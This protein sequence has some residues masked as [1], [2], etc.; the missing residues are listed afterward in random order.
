M[1][2]ASL[3]FCLIWIS[4]LRRIFVFLWL[5]GWQGQR[6]AKF[7]KHCMCDKL[8]QCLGMVSS[9]QILYDFPTKSILCGWCS[10]VCNEWKPLGAFHLSGKKLESTWNAGG[11]SPP[12][13]IAT[14]TDWSINEHVFYLAV[15]LWMP[16]AAVSVK[17]LLLQEKILLES[18]SEPS[19][20]NVKHQ[21]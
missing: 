6:P 12:F 4:R 13:H 5:C 16:W 8:I 9:N 14:L 3:R 18:L 10:S 15:E 21:K 20:R 17:N 1:S 11:Q 19:N 2:F 7:A